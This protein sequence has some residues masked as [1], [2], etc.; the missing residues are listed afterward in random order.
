MGVATMYSPA[1]RL[2]GALRL[3]RTGCPCQLMFLLV[4]PFPVLS[5][6]IE[7]LPLIADSVPVLAAAE[8]GELWSAGVPQP[9]LC[10]ELC[11]VTVKGFAEHALSDTIAL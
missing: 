9:L 8:L 4:L 2:A 6:A 1:A 7:L 3:V 11:R 5:A 10:R